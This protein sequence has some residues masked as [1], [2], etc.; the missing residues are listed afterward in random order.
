[1]F[2]IAYT[3][4]VS[5]QSWTYYISLTI[6]GSRYCWPTLNIHKWPPFVM[7]AKLAAAFVYPQSPNVQY[8]VS[9]GRGHTHTIKVKQCQHSLFKSSC[10]FVFLEFTSLERVVQVF[11]GKYAFFFFFKPNLPHSLIDVV[12]NVDLIFWY[13]SW[14]RCS[15]KWVWNIMRGFGSWSDWPRRGVGV[16]TLWNG[17]KLFPSKETWKY[18]EQTAPA[19]ENIRFHLL[20]W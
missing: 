7:L 13:S 10:S 8:L 18:I 11:P 12:T 2:S 14:C 5:G 4:C 17:D 6:M 3:G 1:M 15:L 20:L 19:E 9:S 16:D